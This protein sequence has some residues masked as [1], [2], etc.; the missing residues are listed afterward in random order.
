MTAPTD[1]RRLTSRILAYEFIDLLSAMARLHGGDIISLL[2][3]TGVWT[4]N[5]SHL[6]ATTDRYAALHD[7]PPDSQRRPISEADLAAHLCMPR[8]V[9]D[10]YVEALVGT[11]LLERRPGGLVVPSAIFTRPEMLSDANETYRRLISML[12]RLRQGGI[13]LGESADEAK[14]DVSVTLARPSAT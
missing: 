2:V 12:A 11:G 3:F 1:N 10:P 4:A 14:G 6:R 13:S 7:I 9:Q 8:Q 5:T